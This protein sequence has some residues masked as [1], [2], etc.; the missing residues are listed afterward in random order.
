M[1]LTSDW[2]K[3]Q[4]YDFLDQKGDYSNIHWQEI[5]PDRN[6]TWLI[7]GLE[8]ESKNFFPLP[9]KRPGLEKARLFLEIMGMG[10]KP[11]GMPGL[12][13]TVQS[14]FRKTSNGSS[15]TTTTRLANGRI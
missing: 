13:T 15:K 12:T 7:Q 6:Q 1:P 2:R 9:G 11:K 3:E 5:T 4:K 10:F 14:F 8:R